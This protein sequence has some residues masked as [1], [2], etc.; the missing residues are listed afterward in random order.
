MKLPLLILFLSFLVFSDLLGQTRIPICGL[1]AGGE[2]Q[3]ALQEGTRYFK[4]KLF[5][6]VEEIPKGIP[7]PWYLYLED[8]E[9]KPID[10]DAIIRASAINYEA[11]IGFGTP[12]KVERYVGDGHFM[13]EEVSYTLGG[14][15][16]WRFQVQ[17][18]DKV[19]VLSFEVEIELAEN[20]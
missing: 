10:K 5:S 18:G 13:V 17:Q 4:G 1:N 11:G 14:P 3:S 7:H 20:D 16:T 8:M 6:Y 12:P 2:A 19:E 9:G 15:W